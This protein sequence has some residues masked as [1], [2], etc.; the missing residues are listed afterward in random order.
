MSKYTITLLLLL[1]TFTQQSLF[2]VNQTN[3]KIKKAKIQLP[4]QC[5]FYFEMYLNAKSPKAF[6]YASDSKQ[7][8]TCRF[9]SAADNQKRAEEIALAS[10]QKS[11][12]KKAITSG[13]KIYKTTQTMTKSRKKLNFEEKYLNNLNKIKKVTQQVATITKKQHKIKKQTTNALPKSCVMFYTLFLQAK[14]HKAFALAVDN[15]KNY[16]CRYSA[17]SISKAKAQQVALNSCQKVAKKRKLKNPCQLF[18]LNDDKFLKKVTKTKKK[19]LDKKK[20]IHKKVVSSKKRKQ[21]KQTKRIT[22]PV[23]EKAIL[24]ADLSKIKKL[25]KQGED[26]N[27]EAKDKSRA[28]FVAVAKG[29]I[30][31]TKHLLKKGA[32]PFIK[33]KDGNNLLV[34]AIMSGN[35]Q[36]LTLMLE[37]NI[38]PNIR[39][40]E[41]NTPLHFALMM[42][43]DKM[44]KTLYKFNARDDIKNNKGQSVQ[45][46]AK[47]L[48]INL[49]IIKR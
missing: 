44:M 10:C 13:C 29:D 36:M 26:V 32:F 33:K 49:K 37:Q 5:H 11:A 14:E 42:F 9:S 40:E 46:M 4:E 24:E 47:E 38:D 41:G 28:L 15:E 23:L 34:A 25:I 16:A 48:R 3:D 21:T 27:V 45:E 31:F 20:K 39:C 35:N 17:G 6:S 30:K 8:V 12:K 2:A 43:D 7:N 1:F 19:T 22:S 18:L